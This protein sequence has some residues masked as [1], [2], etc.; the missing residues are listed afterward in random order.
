MS[1]GFSL[2]FSIWHLRLTISLVH[3][4]EYPRACKSEW[5]C[6]FGVALLL[7]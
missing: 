1:I 7:D 6:L 4:I 3:I 2:M 5:L